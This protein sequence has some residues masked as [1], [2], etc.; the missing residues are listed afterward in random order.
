MSGIKDDE[1][2]QKVTVDFP[3]WMVVLLDK[4]A[5]RLGIARKS[6]IK[7]IIDQ[8]L[9]ELYPNFEGREAS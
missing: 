4:E 5:D 2:Y 7:V 1:N 8:R 9:S 6:V 3:K